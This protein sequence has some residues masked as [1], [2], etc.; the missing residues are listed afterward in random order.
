MSS[1]LISTKTIDFLNL[2]IKQEE[3]SSRLYEQIALF[4]DDEGY[5]NLAKLYRQYSTEEMAHADWAKQ[6]LLD[7]GL[8]PKLSALEE[9]RKDYQSPK[10][11][12][13]LTLEHEEFIT[14]EINKIAVEALKENDFVL[15][16]LANR[17]Q[18]EQ[19]EEIGKAID[20]QDIEKLTKDRLVLDNYVG[21][22]ILGA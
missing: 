4:F 21:E 5:F 19:Q 13:D 1:K 9:P 3:E 16:Q 22:H 14:T 7:F 15:F 8:T 2:R 10:E 11:I 18:A 12:F 6:Y 17:Y 20:L